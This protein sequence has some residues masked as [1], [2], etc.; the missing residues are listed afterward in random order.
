MSV[1]MKNVSKEANVS[2][3]AK[4][5]AMIYFESVSFAS[6]VCRC[7]LH[8]TNFHREVSIKFMQQWKCLQ[9][10]LFIDVVQRQKS[11]L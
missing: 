5:I 9:Y 3:V 4:H 11:S 10:L 8:Y 2:N 1:K 7:S 6:I